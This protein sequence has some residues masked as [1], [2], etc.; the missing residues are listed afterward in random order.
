MEA[1]P[2]QRVESTCGRRAQHVDV[3]PCHEFGKGATVVTEKCDNL[4]YDCSILIGKSQLNTSAK[5]ADRSASRRSKASP[6]SRAASASIRSLEACACSDVVGIRFIYSS[7]P[8][9]SE[10]ST[11]ARRTGSVDD[12]IVHRT[13]W[14]RTSI[15]TSERLGTLNQRSG[16]S[17]KRNPNRMVTYF[18]YVDVHNARR[19]E[20]H[21][22]VPG[23]GRQAR[24]T[25]SARHRC[26]LA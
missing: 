1:A 3:V 19:H 4:R 9:T 23:C 11:R 2:W 21:R 13:P 24:Q 18:Q 17:G 15:R 14:R 7:S 12:G 6:S 25:E 10:R 26:L 16:E 20:A 22:K 8:D 5:H